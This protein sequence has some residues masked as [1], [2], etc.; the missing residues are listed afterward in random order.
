[1]THPKILKR[2]L[3]ECEKHETSQCEMIRRAE[4]DFSTLVNERG[5]NPQGFG[6]KI[7]REENKLSELAIA[8]QENPTSAVAKSVYE[9][10]LQT[11]NTLLA[12]VAATTSVS[13]S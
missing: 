13:N 6:K 5:A 2:Q 12:V 4:D 3:E 10:Q 8:H 11:V 7:M 9:T 1:M